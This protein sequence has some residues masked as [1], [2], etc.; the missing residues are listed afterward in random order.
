M[1]APP[2]PPALEEAEAFRRRGDTL[3]CEKVP[4]PAIAEQ[5]GTPVY[6]Y[7]RAAL[8]G[9]LREL[10]RAFQGVDHLICYSVKA[11]SNLAVLELLGREGAGADVVSSGELHRA[12]RAGIPPA[13][14]VF[15]GVGKTAAEI[16]EA[17]RAGIHLLNCESA[18]ELDTVAAIAARLGV[19]APVA[20]RLNPGVDALTHDHVATGRRDSKFGLEAGELPALYRRIA[21]SPHL[22]AAGIDM[23]I[24]SQIVSPTPFVRALEVLRDSVLALRG[25]GIALR[26]VDL[27]GGLGI[28]YNHEPPLRAAEFAGAVRPLLADLGLALVLEP[29]RFIAGPAGVLVARVLYVKETAAKTFVILDAAMNDLIRPTLYGAFHRLEPV[30]SRGRPA[31]VADWVGPVCESGDFL[32]RDRA[33]ERP[34]AGDL[35]AVLDAGAYGATMASNYNTRPRA[36]EVLVEGDRFRVIRRRETFEDLVRLEE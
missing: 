22:E 29:G 26:T 24:G 27:G 31:I 15:S 5:A 16:A 9:R 1:A 13:R 3:F 10:D 8:V 33:A 17:L 20:L 18:P 34:E 35:V 25:Q 23:H 6:V 12:M 36:P 21:A 2:H 4:L 7:S 28:A 11:N 32:A 19:R 30:V 14:I